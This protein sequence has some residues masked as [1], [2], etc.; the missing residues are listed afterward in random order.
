[1]SS[2]FSQI[3]FSHEDEAPKVFQDLGKLRAKNWSDMG[4]RIQ[5]LKREV[6]FCCCRKASVIYYQWLFFIST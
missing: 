4:G 3:G 2:V 5:E 6:H 1:M